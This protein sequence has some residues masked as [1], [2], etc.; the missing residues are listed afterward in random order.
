[1]SCAAAL[2]TL[3]VIEDED[4]VANARARGAQLLGGLRELQVD[5]GAIGD[6][7]G[8][9]CMVGV[10][11]VRPGEGDGR[12]PDPALTKRVIA[13]ALGRQLIVLSAGS[14]VN[15][16]RLIPTLV[17]TTDEVDRALSILDDSLTAAGA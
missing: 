6:V 2:A 3:D 10:E 16:S 4:L 9:G 7:R 17:T 14:Y 13:E 11:F 15:V 12:V 1:M 5:H 8:L